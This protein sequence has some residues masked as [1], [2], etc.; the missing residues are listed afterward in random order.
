MLVE[1]GMAINEMKHITNPKIKATLQ[2]QIGCKW[3]CVKLKVVID[4]WGNI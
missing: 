4:T 3:I 1:G 2:S